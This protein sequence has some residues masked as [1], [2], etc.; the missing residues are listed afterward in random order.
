MN[1]KDILKEENKV[2][3]MYL[4]DKNSANKI[5]KIFNVSTKIILEILKKNGVLIRSHSESMKIKYTTEI[6]N[7]ICE[8]YIK[9]TTPINISKRL[10]ISV[11][12]I[13]KILEENNIKVRGLHKTTSHITSE[14]ETEI[15]NL[16]SGGEISFLNL[17]KKFDVS[18][19][20]IRKIISKNNISFKHPGKAT[21]E[22]KKNIIK[23]NKRRC[24]EFSSF[25]GK[26]PPKEHCWGNGDW[27]NSPSQGKIWIRSGWEIRYA[28]FLDEHG[29]FWTYETIAFPLTLNNRK[30]TYR[31]DFYLVDYD[32]YIDVK[33][34]DEWNKDKINHF[35]NQYPE[36]K[37]Q[38]ISEKD[39]T[40]WGINLRKQIYVNNKW[41]T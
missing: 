3:D 39:L 31:P 34:R 1:I 30:T 19:N 28:L 21:E 10:N 11:S 6:E 29:I 38:I 5:S 8:M 14:I 15:C 33:G 7:K 32:I 25:F 26:I 20:T 41:R 35:Q 23:S 27:Y 17:G 13:R 24:G 40:N 12:P 16:Y 22:G 9:G 36:I 18:A 37:L 4:V 2:C